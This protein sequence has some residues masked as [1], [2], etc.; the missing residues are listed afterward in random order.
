LPWRKHDIIQTSPKPYDSELQ[1]LISEG[2]FFNS[3]FRARLDTVSFG[4]LKSYPGCFIPIRFDFTPQINGSLLRWRDAAIEV[5]F[6]DATK[7]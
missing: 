2:A 7:S 5:E 4:K 6:N 3:L 1:Q